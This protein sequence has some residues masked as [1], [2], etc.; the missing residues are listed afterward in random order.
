LLVISLKDASHIVAVNSDGTSD[1]PEL[2]VTDVGLSMG[3]CGTE[4]AKEASHIVMLDDD[5]RSIV[6]TMCV[7]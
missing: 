3:K 7:E 5:C 2:I 4:P 6:R 1:V